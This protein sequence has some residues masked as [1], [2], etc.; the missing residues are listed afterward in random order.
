MV[1]MQTYRHIEAEYTDSAGVFDDS[2][3]RVLSC[4]A[5]LRALSDA[6]R[7]LFVLYVETG[8]VRKLSEILGVSKSTVQN[9]VKDIRKRILKNM[10]L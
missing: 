7:R 9:R 5:A 3:L 2:D 10:K 8:S 6:D 1:D 4:K